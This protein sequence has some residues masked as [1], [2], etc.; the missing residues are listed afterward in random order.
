[1]EKSAEEQSVRDSRR[2]AAVAMAIV[3]EQ[4]GPMKKLLGLT[5]K[6]PWPALA[7]SI[8]AGLLLGR[9]LRGR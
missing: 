7:V 6:H 3:E 8:L 4:T 1:M 5:R 9:I 2:R